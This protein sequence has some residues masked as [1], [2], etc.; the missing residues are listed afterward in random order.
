MPDHLENMSRIYSERNWSLY[1]FLDQTLDPRGPDYLYDLAAEYVNSGSVIL[2]AGCRNG[3]HLIR[4]VQDHHAA[5]VG[6]DPVEAH[7]RQA[8]AAVK[9][10]GLEHRVQ[11]RR[12][13]M[14]ALPYPNGH[15]DFVWCRDVL[16]N[17]DTL[18]AAMTEMARVL[19]LD[20]HMLVYTNFVTGRLE[21]LEARMMNRHLGNVPESLI[22]GHVERVF[23]VAG[24]AVVRKD[25]IGTEW[26]EYAEERTQPV[27][28]ALLRL[29][30]LRRQRSVVVERYG[31]ETYDHVE[32]NLHWLLY[33]F[34]GKLQPTVYLLR[35][36]GNM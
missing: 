30:R 23:A 19:A 22:E 11:I 5:G 26:R 28:Q 9:D 35:P 32:A 16:E 6:V 21:P 1:E 36:R 27:S 24:F 4:L 33:Q 20:G 17:V 25:L 10:A 8:T 2:D 31:Q 14:E 13:V 3:A 15:F 18:Q 34:L 29:A 12:G 7:I